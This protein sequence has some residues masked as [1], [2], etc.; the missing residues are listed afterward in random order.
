MANN[1]RKLGEDYWKKKLTPKQYQILRMGGTEEPFSGDL[2]N[3]HDK[4]IYQCSAC[5]TTLFS[6]DTKFDSGTGWPSFDNPVN[7]EHIELRDDNSFGTQRTEVLCRNCGS[8]L[9]HV[10]DDGP[11]ETGKRYCINSACLLFNPQK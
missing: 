2:F 11:T 8:H 9:G 1:I 4:G 10:F 3:N 5:G 6:S 7:L